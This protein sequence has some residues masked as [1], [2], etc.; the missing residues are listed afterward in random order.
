MIFAVILLLIIIVYALNQRKEPIR[1]AYAG[2]V[3]LAFG[4]VSFFVFIT[5]MSDMDF[6]GPAPGASVA[7]PSLGNILLLIASGTILTL[8]GLIL[9]KKKSGPSKTAYAGVALLIASVLFFISSIF[10]NFDP[11]TTIFLSISLVL[12]PVG[13]IVTLTGFV[14]HKKKS[15]QQAEL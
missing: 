10:I 9:N 11:F 13:S 2:G 5:L 4:L 12:T 15:T 7:L 1:I 3:M 8:N 14:I 6:S